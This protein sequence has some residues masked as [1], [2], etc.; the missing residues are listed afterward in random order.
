MAVRIGINGFG[1]IGR[2]VLRVALRRPD[3]EVVAVNH[4]SRRLPMDEEFAPKLAHTLKYDSIHGRLEEEI[5][6]HK[7]TI[8]VNGKKIKLLS[9]GDPAALPWGDL[10]VDL[11]VESTG[12]FNSPDKASS[13]LKGGAKKVVISAP[14]KGE[15]LTVVMGVNEELYDPAIHNVVSNASCTTNCL[16]PV[17]KVLHKNFGI[18][19]GLMTTVHAVTNNQQ[20][21]D[22]PSK[23]VR[24]G[25]AATMSIIPTTTGAAKAVALVLPEL[26]G[27]LNGMAMRVPTLNVSVV[28][29]VAQLQ[30]KATR[31]EIN[32]VLKNASE[33]ELKGILAYSELPLVSVDYTSDSHSSIVDGLSTMVM[34]DDMVKILSWYDNEWGYSNRVVDLVEYIAKRG[35]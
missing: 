1:R 12:I 11:V 21:L 31:E 24:R 29:L 35:I 6:G 8:S 5:V 26:K 14:A 27:K 19:K 7:D 33:N 10:G 17:A 20:I 2:L 34:D 4:K 16:A 13:H 28:D 18:V 23:D 30:K 22:M 25:R 9:N 15:C 3:I 32:A